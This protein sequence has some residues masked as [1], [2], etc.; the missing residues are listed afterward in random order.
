MGKIIIFNGPPRSGKDFA[1]RAVSQSIPGSL[2]IGFADKIK[3]DTHARYGFPDIGIFAFE[4]TKDRENDLFEGKTP[5]QAYIETAA[6]NRMRF[7]EQYYGQY[8][9]SVVSHIRPVV[10][11][12]PDAGKPEETEFLVGS[13]GAENCLLVKVLTG[14]RGFEGCNRQWL[15]LKGVQSVEVSN[16]M[17]PAFNAA[18]VGL[19]N[20]FCAGSLSFREKIKPL[21]DNGLSLTPTTSV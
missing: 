12:I 8:L 2:R 4:V 5:R 14:D 18:V 11:L 13:A 21:V 19:V 10:T 7:G 20:N 17:T 3:R 9:W 16:P 1:A 15:S 6:I